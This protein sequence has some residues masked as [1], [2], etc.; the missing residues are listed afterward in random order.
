[1]KRII[2]TG[3]SIIIILTIATLIRNNKLNIDKELM[4][5][6]RSHKT[7]VI[8]DNN[9]AKFNK[10]FV[11]KEY[12]YIDL[13]GD[14]KNELVVLTNDYSG[15][16]VILRYF[17]RKVY[18][19]RVGARSFLDLKEDGT[20]MRSGSAYE[21]TISRIEFVNNDLN[22]ID[23]VTYDTEN[24]KYTVDNKEVNRDELNKYLTEWNNK[25]SKEF[26]TIKK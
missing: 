24:K 12:T 17:N 1:M 13:D 10:L 9:K 7:F 19:Y 2:I 5:V 22:Y 25:K 11:P 4:N 3:V 15:E 18:G 21:S 26:I 23:I 16:Y 6:M 20:F 8:D 14:K